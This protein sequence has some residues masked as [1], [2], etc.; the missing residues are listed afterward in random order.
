MSIIFSSRRHGIVV[1]QHAGGSRSWSGQYNGASIKCAVPIDSGKR[2]ILLLDPEANKLAVFEN[3]LCIDRNG[4]LIWTA[5]L[6]TSPDVFLSISPSAAG[7]WVNTW[8]GLRILLDEN[9]G[10]ERDRAFVK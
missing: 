5:K 1:S 6:P 7:I 10:A 9:T 2:C 3:L 8:S 4:N